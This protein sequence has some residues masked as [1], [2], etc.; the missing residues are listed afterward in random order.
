M[1][2]WQGGCLRFHWEEGGG[3]MSEGTAVIAHCGLTALPVGFGVWGGGP[4]GVFA[5]D[6]REVKVDALAAAGSGAV[7]GLYFSAHWCP[8]CRGFTPLLATCYAALK[9][10][11]KP[12]EIVFLSSDK[13]Q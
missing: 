11:G 5:N 12:F 6:G 13:D 1:D 10:A 7:V 2:H 8:P 3:A 9:S 4:F